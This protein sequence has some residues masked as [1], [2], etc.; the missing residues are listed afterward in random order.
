M[1]SVYSDDE[2]QED[3]LVNLVHQIR[4]PSKS[5]RKKS[6]PEPEE[7]ESRR[8]SH[9][10]RRK[11]KAESG[12]SAVLDKVDRI[13]ELKK[14]SKR[15]KYSDDRMM[16]KVD[17]IL[18]SD[19]SSAV[20]PEDKTRAR[21]KFLDQVDDIL[22]LASRQEEQE[23]EEESSES[24]EEESDED[25]LTESEMRLLNLINHNKI[26]VKVNF[27]SEYADTD[28]HF[29]RRKETSH[30]LAKCPVYEGIMRGSEF[31][32]LCSDDV[33]TVK[34]ALHNIKSA[35]V[36]RSEALA[37]TS[38]G[39]VSATNMRLLNMD[40]KCERKKTKEEL[41]DEILATT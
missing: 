26:D 23:E 12:K 39:G 20:S 15:K 8:H 10:K 30:H 19:I 4:R 38:L 21:N 29:C 41:I 16:K 24:S 3:L 31:R 14:E 7:V 18:F 33:R 35:L 40:Q 13:L 5:K 25:D 32:D 27:P 11:R 37:V 6:E 22:G 17:R 34:A 28:C 9:R 36:K 1:C 2:E